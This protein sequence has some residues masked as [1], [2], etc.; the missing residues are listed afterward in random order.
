MNGLPTLLARR[1]ETGRIELDIEVP[2]D[3]HWFEGHFPAFAILPG[4]VQIGWAA[5]F[6]HTLCGFGP[7]VR[8][9]EQVK[10]KR[11]ILPGA[12]LILSLKPDLTAGRLR[13]EY[14]EAD[15]VCSSGSL[16]YGPGSDA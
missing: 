14:R 6:G 10:F 5:H 15:Q 12:R 16:V 9:M 3:S 11:P 1:D 7:G 4:V 2:V 8:G 13:Y